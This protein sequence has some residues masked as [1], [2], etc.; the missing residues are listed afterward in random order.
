MYH[1][2]PFTL[3]I[4]EILDQTAKL[5][6]TFE[7]THF[8]SQHCMLPTRDDKTQHSQRLLPPSVLSI[9]QRAVLCTGANGLSCQTNI[10][11]GR[12]NGSQGETD[13]GWLH[14]GDRKLRPPGVTLFCSCALPLD[15]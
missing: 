12:G 7:I 11:K 15:T 2:Y 5:H 14:Q 13:Q 4:A 10:R 8:D 6:L 3:K 1:I 9:S